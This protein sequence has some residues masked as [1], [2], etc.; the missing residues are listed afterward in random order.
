[1]V[2]DFKIERGWPL[3]GRPLKEEALVGFGK[4]DYYPPISQWRT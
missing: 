1:L 2:L 4:G 3:G